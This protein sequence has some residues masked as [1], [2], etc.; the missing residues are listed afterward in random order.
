MSDVLVDLDR[1]KKVFPHREKAVLEELSA[2]IMTGKVTGLVGPDG[3]GKTTLMR[4][5]QV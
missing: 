2:R 5:R 4:L 3:A 1:V